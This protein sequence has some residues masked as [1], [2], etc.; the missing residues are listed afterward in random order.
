SMQADSNATMALAFSPHGDALAT[1][2]VDQKIHLWELRSLQEQPEPR[3]VSRKPIT[4]NEIG[5]WKG[6][7]LEVWSVAFSPD[8]QRLAS[9]ATDAP[10]KF[11]PA[12]PPPAGAA[13][14]RARDPLIFSPN[15][16][17]FLTFNN[18][19]TLSWWAIRPGKEI[20]R[21]DLTIPA[22]GLL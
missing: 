9:G 17:E 12:P 22:E 18:E 19:A 5:T 7:K 16:E 14:L 6:H 21:L 15:G 10:A 20:R 1:A 2:G 4:L 11:W 8:G 13:R 3:D